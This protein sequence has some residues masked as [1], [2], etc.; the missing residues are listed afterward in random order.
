MSLYPE[1]NHDQLTP[2]MVLAVQTTGWAAAVIR[3]GEEVSGKPNI[4]NHV[5]VVHHLDNN[6]VWW[7]VEGRP[8][9]VGWADLRKYLGHPQTVA[10]VGQHL[11]IAGP[12]IATQAALML[13][14]AYD[15]QGIAADAL[16]DLHI[17]DLFAQNWQGQGAPGHVVCSSFAAWLYEHFGL[18]HPSLGRERF[19]QPSDWTKFIED[20]GW[21]PP[22]TGLRK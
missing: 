16:N 9:G 3:M 15:W 8:G 10:N 5:V 7:G 19:C 2:G 20:K 6:G 12:Q 17:N 21:D 14:T 18:A 4:D 22:S 13:G 11:G 1:V